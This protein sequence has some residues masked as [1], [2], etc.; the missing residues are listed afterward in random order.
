MR[1]SLNELTRTCQKAF[2]GLGFPAGV[3]RDAARMVAW[4]ER[5]GLP[6]LARLATELEALSARP[7][8]PPAV[9]G[10]GPDT[11]TLDAGGQTVL[12]AA[13]A[14][15]DL[16]RAGWAAAGGGSA[17]IRDCRAPLLG[18]PAPALLGAT[19]CWFRSRWE[20]GGGAFDLVIDPDGRPAL[21]GD[22]RALAA[23]PG[24]AASLG[25]VC[26][27]GAA[28]GFPAAVRP[29]GD[30]PAAIAP[31]DFASRERHALAEG[32][33]VDAK[34]WEPIAALAA[35]ILVDGTEESRARGAGG[36]RSDND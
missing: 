2:E 18:A 27:G 3:D 9:V 25:Y 8:R 26:T 4:L 23:V 12:L 34:T 36:G 6:G 30:A 33:R 7:P 24:G 29:R 5:H 16:A 15:L 32:V 31:P 20:E 35:R 22:E 11:M 14:A 28:A 17:T 1:V 19:G 21:Y 13:P 10:D